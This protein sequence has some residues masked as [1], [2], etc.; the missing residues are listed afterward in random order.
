[1]NILFD[2]QKYDNIGQIVPD[3]FEIESRKGRFLKI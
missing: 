3:L 2:L 1:M